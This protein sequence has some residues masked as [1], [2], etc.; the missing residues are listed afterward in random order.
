ADQDLP[1]DAESLD[2]TLPVPDLAEGRYTLAVELVRGAEVIE[3]SETLIRKLPKV[4]HEWR[5]GEENVLLHNGEPVLP[6]G[7][8][9]MPVEEIAKSDCPYS[10]GQDY[11]GYWYSVEENRAKWDKYAAA[12]KF[13]TTYPYPSPKM[14]SPEGV[15]GKPLTDEEA[16]ALRERVRALKDH[17]AVFAWYLADEPEL[18]PALPERTRR[19]YEIVADEDPYHPCIM[20]ND[21]IAGVYKYV[22]GGDVLMPDPYPCFI[23]DGFAAT[24]IEK[25]TEFMRACNEA[26]AGRRALWITPQAFNYGDYGRENNRAPTF[27]ELRNMTY[28]A[29]IEET[30]GFLYYTWEHSLNYMGVQVG[31]PFLAKEV[32]DLKDVILA[33]D[34]GDDVEVDAP[35]PEHIQASVRN[36]N[37]HV[38]LFVT[39]TAT[40]PQDVR[41]TCPGLPQNLDQFHVVSEDRTVAVG[42]GGVVTDRFD[43]YGT[44]IYTCD[45]DTAQRQT[46]AAAKAEVDKLDAA[47]KRPDNLAFEDNGTTIAVSSKSTYGS[48]PERL[49]DGMR[50]GMGWRDKT[51]N[52]LPDWLEIVW[53]EPVTVGRLV[54]FTNSVEDVAVLVPVGEG[55]K[56]LASVTGATEPEVTIEFPSVTTDRLRLE[57]RKN[58][59]DQKHTWITEVEAYRE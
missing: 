30:K 59:P 4:A 28:Q 50:E 31:M 47:R 33:P 53:P 3:R 21:T 25:V 58:R 18:R 37:D 34:T 43:M 46:V 6:F 57:V 10:V 24:P 41:L 9:S 7:W 45:A 17:P 16:T 44:H 26:G 55:W 11:G 22:D 13:V 23:A 29:V 42:A 32:A 54:A 49:V 2:V 12:G 35:L 56:E 38:Y 52:A 40:G 48:T 27:D 20:L 14:V 19:I 5:I 51:A 36:A 39:N 1:A 8:F 15:W